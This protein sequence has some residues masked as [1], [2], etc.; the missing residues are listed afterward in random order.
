MSREDSKSD[1]RSSDVWGELTI[2]SSCGIEKQS[3]ILKKSEY[4]IGRSRRCDVRIGIKTVS[5][6]HVKIK[7]DLVTRKSTLLNCG[8]ED[9]LFLNDTLVKP[10]EEVPLSFGDIIKLSGKKFKLRSPVEE[11]SVIVDETQLCSQPPI[12]DKSP[13]TSFA[14]GGGVHNTRSLPQRL[15]IM[16]TMDFTTSQRAAASPVGKFLESQAEMLKSPLSLGTPDA[17]FKN[18]SSK[19]VRFSRFNE[20]KSNGQKV[21]SPATKRRR[22]SDR[23]LSARKQVLGRVRHQGTQVKPKLLLTPTV[24]PKT[25]GERR[26]EIMRRLLSD[27]L[28]WR[29]D[30]KPSKFVL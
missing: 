16:K 24:K 26:K 28:E 11:H 5:R 23:M 22:A 20:I 29:E 10:M 21:Y 2:I 9:D 4:T 30:D 19:S 14:P 3:M 6:V 7:Y 17:E 8:K 27:T 13:A 25:E 15:E 12:L 18:N 1:R